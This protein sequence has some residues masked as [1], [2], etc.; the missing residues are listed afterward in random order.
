MA[1][2]GRSGCESLTIASPVAYNGDQGNEPLFVPRANGV[3]PIL[4][5]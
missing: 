4:S 3:D 5:K 1:L 2:F